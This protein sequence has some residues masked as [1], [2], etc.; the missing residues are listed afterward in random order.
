MSPFINEIELA[1]KILI[2]NVI[3]TSFEYDIDEYDRSLFERLGI[4][5]LEQLHKSVAKR[6]AE[7]LAGRYAA[8]QALIK[9]GRIDCEIPI[10]KNK[11]PVWPKGIIASI[12]H[13]S[14]KAICAAATT[15]DIQY[16]GIDLENF[17]TPRTAD[18]IKSI[19]LVEQE[20]DLM[21]SM[22]LDFE[23]ALTLVF[24]AKESIF[25][26]LHPYVKRYFD[27]SSVRLSGFYPAKDCIEFTLTKYLAPEY[28]AGTKVSGHFIIDE[29]AVLTCI[30]KAAE[31]RC[32]AALNIS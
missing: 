32:A 2:E 23:V 13:T 26:A 18:N 20:Y 16:V 12:T 14:S 3:V 28:V 21:R 4:A 19:V 8:T 29:R 10:G 9:L 27:F 6:Q 30:Y 7:F 1:K 25:K 24:S 17:L 31:N 11:S 22:G 5:Y 15:E